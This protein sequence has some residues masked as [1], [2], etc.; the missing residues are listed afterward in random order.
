MSLRIGWLSNGPHCNTGYGTQTAQMLPRLRDAGHEVA[1]FANYGLGG[2]A[3]YWNGF[4][5][6][7]SALKPDLSDLVHGHVE[8]WKTDVLV[9][10]YDSFAMNP[11]VLRR[12]PCQ[13]CFWEPVD[14]EPMSRPSLRA[15][16]VSGAQP[17]AMSRFGEQ[18]LAD[19][20]LDPL[21]APHGIDL[22]VF[23]PAEEITGSSSRALARSALRAEVGIPADSFVI[24]MNVHNKD[25]ERKAVFE[26]M[27]AFA[28]FHQRHDDT[29]LM[30]HSLPHPVMS[31]LNMIDLASYLGISD[32]VR[33]ADP[34]SLL[35][36]N[37]TAGDMAKWYARMDLFSGASRAEGFGLPIVEAQ[38]CGVPVVVTDAS[39][40][41]ELAGP[42]Y[43]I[44]GQPCWQK[45]HSAT[46][47]T[48]DIGELV[49][50]YED[51][52]SG[53]AAARSDD[54][55]KFAAGYG[56]DQVFSEHWSPLLARLEQWL[57]DGSVSLTGRPA[58]GWRLVK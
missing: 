28:L 22:D 51:A 45:G 33:W 34:Y 43:L 55:V 39:A 37:Y 54:A 13:V 1:V 53:G 58:S 8:D 6:Y 26:Q 35:A 29:I 42:G 48:P 44:S 41:T 19:E 32:A 9:I 14:C 50:A 27:A 57:S 3:T 46:W 7:P 12:L 36:G 23:R 25:A 2:S 24:G 56:A 21:Y 20:G 47:F 38:A 10:L 30:V 5:V 11:E 16:K 18:M 49:A 40:M 4:K 52:Y 15:F 17:I 31:E